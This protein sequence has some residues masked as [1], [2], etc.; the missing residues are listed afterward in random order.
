GMLLPHLSC[1]APQETKAALQVEDRGALLTV[2]SDVAESRCEITVKSGC[3][4]TEDRCNLLWPSSQQRRELRVA[5]AAGV[6]LREQGWSPLAGP[7]V[8]IA[9]RH[10]TQR[11]PRDKDC[12]RVRCGG[13]PLE[14]VDD[15]SL[16]AR[17]RAFKEQPHRWPIGHNT[18]ADCGGHRQLDHVGEGRAAE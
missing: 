12:D 14:H 11:D 2:L 9:A 15:G 16:S 7:G 3:E 5:P 4:D 1:D 18:S 10:R 6:E 13:Q 8:F 17:R